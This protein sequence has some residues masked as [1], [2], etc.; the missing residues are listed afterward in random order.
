MKNII[1][2]LEEKNI[3]TYCYKENNKLC[4]YELST[5]TDGGVNIIIF[6]DFRGE[7][8]NVENPKKFKE[9]LKEYINYFD[10]DEEIDIYRQDPR[11]CIDFT[12]K[13][14]LKD[15]GGWKKCIKKLI[16]QI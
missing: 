14:S 11:Y 4:G 12:I 7:E 6:L 8:E 16:K 1:E 3:T 5:Y 13:K 10:V 15:F 9:K 2:L